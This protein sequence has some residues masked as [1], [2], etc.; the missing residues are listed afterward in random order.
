MA[1]TI[2]GGVDDKTYFGMHRTIPVGSLVAVRNEMNDQMVLV[3]I[4]GKLPDTGINDKVIIRLS[5]SAVKQLRA[6]DPKFRVEITYLRPE[7]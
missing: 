2:E 4:V 1:A 7:E 5:E 3:R 6:I